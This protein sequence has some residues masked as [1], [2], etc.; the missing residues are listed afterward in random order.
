MRLVIFDVDGTLTDTMTIDAHCFLSTFRDVCGFA[1]VESDWSRYTN[2]TD[3]G[4]LH[5]VFELRIGR[6]PSPTEMAHFREHLVALFRV[7]AEIRP[8]DPVRGAPELLARLKQGNEYSIALATGCWADAAR[9]KMS[10]AGM[11]YDDYPSASADDGPERDSIIKL[12]LARAAGSNGQKLSDVIYVGDGVWD[13]HACGKVGI[14]F[15]GIAANVQKEKL[16]VAGATHVLP[17]FSDQARFFASVE[18]ILA[19]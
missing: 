8:F 13:I 12:A 19:I 2:P 15:L 7:A 16:I 17:D 6:P 3:A 5:E 9:V 4:I 10:S 11:R 14:H 18:N 1:D